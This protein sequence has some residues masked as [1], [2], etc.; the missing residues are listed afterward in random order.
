MKR[1][2]S[3]TNL[4]HTLTSTDK[5]SVVD[6]SGDRK[7]RK[8]TP[9]FSHQTPADENSVVADI[10]PVTSSTG[11]RRCVLF[12]PGEGTDGELG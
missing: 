10:T 11:R 5:N 3:Y 7:F 2:S 4:D 6:W 8:F 12:S 9:S 1:M